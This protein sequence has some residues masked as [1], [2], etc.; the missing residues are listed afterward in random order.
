MGSYLMHVIQKIDGISRP[1]VSSWPV[2]KVVN[3]NGSGT[4]SQAEIEEIIGAR[5]LAGN[6]SFAT[7]IL[8]VPARNVVEAVINF[9]LH[10][11]GTN[12]T[13]ERVVINDGKTPGISTGPRGIVPV[14]LQCTSLRS[15]TPQPITKLNCAPASIA[16]RLLKT[17]FVSSL[18]PGEVLLRCAI[19]ASDG[20]A[21]SQDGAD[22]LPVALVPYQNAI[23]AAL[24]ASGVTGWLQRPAGATTYIVLG[25]AQ[26]YNV[27]EVRQNPALKGVL[28]VVQ[29]VTR[30]ALENLTSRQVTQGKKKKPTAVALAKEMRSRGV[31]FDEAALLATDEPLP[32]VADNGSR[33]G[34][35]EA[36]AAEAAAIAL[37]EARQALD[38]GDDEPVFP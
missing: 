37:W 31:D 33:P 26:Y 32:P 21:G 2:K 18:T 8:P 34:Q 30:L 27:E 13:I 11:Q 36:Q 20:I 17:P 10:T 24:L 16:M 3:G 23:K 19:L 5:L 7:E 28:K 9:H 4:A 6:L 1:K 22:M 25:Q 12:V 29:Q 35:A 38:A 15:G 14:A